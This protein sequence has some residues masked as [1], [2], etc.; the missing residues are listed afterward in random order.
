MQPK[1]QQTPPTLDETIDDL[2]DG[3]DE[4]ESQAQQAAIRRQKTEEATNA[5]NQETSTKVDGFIEFAT[6]R[7][8]T[9]V[10]KYKSRNRVARI[11]KES[12]AQLVFPKTWS[13]STEIK[14][15]VALQFQ[16]SNT[17][18][19]A[20]IGLWRVLMPG[21]KYNH[22]LIVAI[23]TNAD[24]NTR[25]VIGSQLHPSSATNERIDLAIRQAFDLIKSNN[26]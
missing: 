14:P 19:F 3:L 17:P 13:V 24:A 4:Q 12:T 9:V 2:L 20:E 26:Y 10:A 7:F 15:G 16:R 22:S 25:Q 21:A 6:A 8:E 11:E 1:E 5:R 23:T 18:G